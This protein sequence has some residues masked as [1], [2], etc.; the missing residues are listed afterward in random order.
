MQKGNNGLSGGEASAVGHRDRVDSH[1]K[2]QCICVE[3]HIQA[4]VSSRLFP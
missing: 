1:S 3:V 2:A 4:H